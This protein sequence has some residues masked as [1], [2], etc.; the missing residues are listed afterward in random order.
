[1]RR[2]KCCYSTNGG[3]P[4]PV[5]SSTF[6][7]LIQLHLRAPS[8]QN[9]A[10]RYRDS[11]YLESR[12]RFLICSLLPLSR[13][14]LRNVCSYVHCCDFS[15]RAVQ[16]VKDHESYEPERCNA[17]QCDIT[18]DQL[19]DSVPPGSVDCLT[20]YVCLVIFI[21]TIVAINCHNRCK[22]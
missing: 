6:H 10:T 14:L 2:W 9:L 13:K 21:T 16:F 11:A 12:C 8:E 19:T 4:N 3:L 7:M 18:S 17:F 20:M 15:P 1:M 22:F 5:S